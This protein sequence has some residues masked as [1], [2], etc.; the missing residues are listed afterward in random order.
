MLLVTSPEKKKSVQVRPLPHAKHVP[1]HYEVS[2]LRQLLH[3]ECRLM[4]AHLTL[5]L[6]TSYILQ[7]HV[8]MDMVLWKFAVCCCA[9]NTVTSSPCRCV[10]RFWRKRNV[11]T[12]ETAPLL[13]ARRREKCGC[14]WKIMTVSSYNSIWFDFVQVLCYCLLKMHEKH[15]VCLV[16]PNLCL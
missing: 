9:I 6:V 10:Y 13:T 5:S 16:T 15:P 3:T 4:P 8:H 2:V 14:T 12:L 1:N 11:A 7:Y